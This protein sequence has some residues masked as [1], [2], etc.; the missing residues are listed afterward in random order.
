MWKLPRHKADESYDEIV[1]TSSGSATEARGSDRR[2]SIWVHATEKR[3]GRHLWVEVAHGEVEGRSE[4][5]AL[6]VHR[7][8]ESL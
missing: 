4:K 5:V 1:G 7:S 3:Y 8:R 2:S 6:C